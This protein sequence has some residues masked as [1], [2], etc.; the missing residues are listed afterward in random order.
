MAL[1]C[2]LNST[3]NKPADL[4]NMANWEC[5]WGQYL[6][7]KND[8]LKVI[9]L[10]MVI[11]SPL[12]CWLLQSTLKIP[13]GILGASPSLNI[14]HTSGLWPRGEVLL[15]PPMFAPTVKWEQC[16]PWTLT[17]KITHFPK[18]LHRQAVW[19]VIRCGW[20]DA[21]DTLE[22]SA[23]NQVHNPNSWSLFYCFLWLY[24]SK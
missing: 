12:G 2:Q 15:R 5:S 14:E 8:L 6:H 23:S 7:F 18:E 10:Q 21:E 17:V 24:S 20:I 11:L 4:V 3:R 19:I 13:C 16:N 22:I 9:G 1:P